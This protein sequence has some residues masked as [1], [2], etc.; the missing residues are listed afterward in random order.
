MLKDRH[1]LGVRGQGSFSPGD[2]VVL[3]DTKSIK[4]KMH[5]AYKGPFIIVGPEGFQGK[6]YYLW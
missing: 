3:Y 6:S 4:K 1:D 2:L 5:R